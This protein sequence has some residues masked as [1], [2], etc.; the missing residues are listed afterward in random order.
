VDA[1]DDYSRSKILAAVGDGD[2]HVNP[3]A[4]AGALK[5]A[6]I[7]TTVSQVRALAVHLGGSAELGAPRAPILAL[8]RRSDDCGGGGGGGDTR[9]GGDEDDGRG[10]RNS[11]DTSYT[12]L[13]KLQALRKGAKSAFEPGVSSQG[14]GTGGGAQRRS[15]RSSVAFDSPAR[16]LPPPDEAAAA[17][18]RPLD[19]GHLPPAQAAAG[20]W[21]RLR[22]FCGARGGAAALRLFKAHDEGGRGSGGGGEAGGK[23]ELDAAQF[24]RCLGAMGVVGL[25]DRVVGD[26]MRRA[27]SSASVSS[28]SAAAM[29]GAGSCVRCVYKRA[30]LENFNTDQN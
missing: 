24:A 19:V 10:A 17:L 29:A 23:G 25:T 22:A 1:L 15:A 30:L 20:A 5:A 27:A 26:V 3:T 18:A 4:L 9:G 8:V 7:P 2:G 6:G 12:M 28:S 21:E 13:Q 11:A 16:A 14:S